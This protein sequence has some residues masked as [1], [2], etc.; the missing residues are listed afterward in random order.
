MAVLNATS[1]Q[2]ETLSNTAAKARNDIQRMSQ[3]ELRG[4]TMTP[5]QRTRIDAELAA[6]KAA[7]DAVV[8]A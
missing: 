4:A 7:L 1:A 8:A 3:G 5:A 2:L 6:L